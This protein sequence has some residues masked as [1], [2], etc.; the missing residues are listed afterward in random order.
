MY[1]WHRCVRNC[2]SRPNVHE[3]VELKLI[4]K[5]PSMVCVSIVWSITPSIDWERDSGTG[6][7]GPFLSIYENVLQ[8]GTVNDVH[9][10]GES[11]PGIH[12]AERV[13][14]D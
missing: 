9:V 6:N 8:P 14:V 5:T 13:D 10:R 2:A 3:A 12:W 11:T 7:N 4:Y 1:V